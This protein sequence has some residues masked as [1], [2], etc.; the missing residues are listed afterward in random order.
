MKKLI[1]FK[2]ILSALLFISCSAQKNVKTLPF[3]TDEVYFQRWI[4]GQRLTGGGT[5]FYIKFKE[6]FSVN[7]FL[8]KVYF[9]GKE[10]P[11]EKKDETVYTANFVQR[12]K[13]S[14]LILDQN[15]ANEYG[16]TAPEISK[17]KFKLI[18]NEAILEF[19][20][21]KKIKFYKISNI[22]EKELLAY[23]SA[24]PRN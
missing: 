9:Q 22:K 23:P 3:A 20:I 21:N 1:V 13:D 19:E 4:G 7:F 14:D 6:P 10:A 5:E 17:P 24:K 12:P 2:I 15:P 11:L 16:N 8:K 18:D